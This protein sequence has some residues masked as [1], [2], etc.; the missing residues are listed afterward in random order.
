M[1][2]NY[3]GFRMFDFGFKPMIKFEIEHPKS[4]IRAEHSKQ[5][6]VEPFYN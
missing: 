4:E 6:F 3:F 5:N 1:G 2:V